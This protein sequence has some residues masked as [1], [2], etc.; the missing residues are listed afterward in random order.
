MKPHMKKI[1]QLFFGLSFAMT[2]YGSAQTMSKMVVASAGEAFS[3]TEYR[4]NATLGE[5]LIGLISNENAMMDQ[6]FWAGALAV[7]PMTPNEA[8]GGIIVYP[9]PVEEQVNILTNSNQV[10]GLALFAVDGR[11]AYRKKVDTS[12]LEHQIDASMLAK[13][14]YVLQVSV[15]GEEEK[16]FKV[17]K[18]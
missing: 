16:L 8:L 15:E 13:G 9:N 12:V 18:R 17:I 2:V 7:E 5:P 14:V 1:K 4:L 3:S 11:M 6:G 10:F